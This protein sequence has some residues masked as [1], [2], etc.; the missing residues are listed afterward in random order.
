MFH[1]HSGVEGGRS[2]YAYTI[3]VVV[4]LCNILDVCFARAF[5]CV[6]GFGESFVRVNEAKLCTSWFG[7]AAFGFFSGAGASS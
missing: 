5:C 6:E 1:V 7:Y 2:D 4:P 3:I